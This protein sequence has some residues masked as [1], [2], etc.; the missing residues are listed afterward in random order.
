[1]KERIKLFSDPTPK[2]R[3]K[4]FSKDGSGTK[5]VVCADC[6][7]K[8]ETSAHTTNLLCPKCGSTRF[9][10]LRA[11]SSPEVSP[12]KIEEQEWQKEFNETS[13]ELELRLKEFS[14]TSLSAA[15]FEKEFS[16]IGVT[17]EDLQA[18][19]YANTA[20]DGSIEI[21]SD[22]FLMSRLFSNIKISITK[23]L[24]LDPEVMNDASTGIS[25]LEE[26]SDLSPKSIAIIK[27]I[28]G[29]KVPE[30]DKE[31]W[32]ADSGIQGDLKLE[33]GG[34]NMDTPEFQSLLAE[35]YPD[36][37]E[38]L[39]EVLKTKGIIRDTGDNRLEIIK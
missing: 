34:Q 26:V 23:T 2:E 19:G 28:H 33:F 8:Q 36:A 20:E 10:V 17:S 1:M 35:R 24:E 16:V 21:P 30:I 18:R 22:A 7:F 12:E 31:S 9:N 4:L 5:V 6:G 32:L 38:D 13:D 27:K 3:I 29:F 39:F 14:G 11:I 15:N 25:R 37:P